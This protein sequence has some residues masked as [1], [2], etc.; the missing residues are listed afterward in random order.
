MISNQILVLD[1]SMLVGLDTFEHIV[2][3]Q[4]SFYANKSSQSLS[5]GSMIALTDAA[6]VSRDNE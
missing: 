1:G 2:E 4:T 3:G 6:K 5:S